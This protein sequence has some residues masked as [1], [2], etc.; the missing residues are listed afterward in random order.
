MFFL[1]QVDRL[2][3]LVV[4]ASALRVEDPGLVVKASASRVEDPGF[5]SRWRW[6]FSGS[7][8]TND[9]KIGTPVATLHAPGVMLS[10]LQY[11][12]D[13]MESFICNFYLGVAARKI[14]WADPSLR[15]TSMLLGC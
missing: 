1:I 5:E 4:R 15:Y 9:L 10:V 12:V 7:N 14:V 13:E 11:T 3:G 6:D 2:I 8:H